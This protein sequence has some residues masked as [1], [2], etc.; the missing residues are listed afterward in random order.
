MGNWVDWSNI[1]NN[2]KPSDRDNLAVDCSGLILIVG[3]TIL[4]QSIISN[5]M[6]IACCLL[7]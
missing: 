6:V 4:I 2:L 5:L 3:K 7:P 1:E